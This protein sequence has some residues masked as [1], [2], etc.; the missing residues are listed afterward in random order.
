MQFYSQ[1]TI[2]TITIL[3][4]YFRQLQFEHG[5]T[6]D[7]EDRVRQIEGDIL[8]VNQ[9]MRELAGL[10]YKQADSVSKYTIIFSTK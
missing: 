7:Q 2:E 9:I 4:F 10:V 1:S 6:L 5:L 8:D 3:H